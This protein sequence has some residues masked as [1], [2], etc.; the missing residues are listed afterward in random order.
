MEDTYV[1]IDI[2]KKAMKKFYNHEKYIIENRVSERCL[3]Y[4]YSKYLQIYL[5][6]LNYDNLNIDL[7]YNRNCGKAKSISIQKLSYPDLIIHERGSNRNN[8]LVIEFKKWNNV[9]KD[10]IKRDEE[11]LKCFRS[12]Y[13]F[14]KAFLIIFSK[15]SCEKVVYK[16]Y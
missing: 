5:K 10:V 2:V 16:E 9:R 6:E 7:E 3:V 4:N 8:K 15:D 12:E 13:G 11:K 1:W 14:E